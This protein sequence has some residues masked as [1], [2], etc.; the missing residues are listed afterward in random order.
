MVSFLTEFLHLINHYFFNRVRS[1]TKPWATLVSDSV[2]TRRAAP[3]PS[4][5]AHGPAG[6]TADAK[7]ANRPFRFL[8]SFT[9]F[10]FKTPYSS[11]PASP[12]ATAYLGAQ[13]LQK[14]NT[15]V[16]P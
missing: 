13:L 1:G 14:F 4:I 3:F 5:F 6:G 12:P 2:L 16:H 7:N 9:N 8:R 15:T 10:V 11:L